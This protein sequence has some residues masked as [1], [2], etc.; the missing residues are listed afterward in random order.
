MN[1][2]TLDAL[3]LPG[4]P[5]KPNEDAF[6]VAAAA[7]LV[8][9]GATGLGEPLLDAPSDAAWVS[10]FGSARMLDHFR[11]GQD[12]DR[13]L[14]QALADTEEAFARLRRRAPQETF[15]IPFASMMFV[16]VAGENLQ[17]RWFG[18]CACLVHKPGAGAEIL[19]DAIAKRAKESARV[20]KLAAS[21]GAQAAA[22]GVRDIFLPALKR[23]RNTVNTEA[24]GWLF[25][26]DA[27]AA[28]HVAQTQVDVSGGTLVLL[29]TDGFLALASD[30][31]RY[32]LNSLLDAAQ[33]RGLAALGDELRA[34]ESTDPDGKLFP[35]FKK[36]DDAT[37]VLLRVRQ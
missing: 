17:A 14:A 5:D 29:M 26:P 2:E 36:S 8:M 6:G 12:P 22:R 33:T 11:E 3:S 20:A 9:D 18:D 23:A 16:S 25:G 30:Y 15:E 37:A 4:D 1:F 31:G 27:L 32:T 7:A 21:L 13:A 35:R 34:L 24:G 28:T 10:R 19:G